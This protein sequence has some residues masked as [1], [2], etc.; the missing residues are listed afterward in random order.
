[1]IKDRKTAF[2]IYVV[3]FIV[4]WNI[5]EIL[6]DLFTGGAG[7]TFSAV[8][9]IMTPLGL[10]IVT[11]YLLF[12]INHA[13]INDELQTARSTEGSVIV[14]VRNPEEYLAGHIHGAINIPEDNINEIRSMIADRSTPLFTYCLR[15]SRST[16]AA[17]SLK[18]MGYT[19]VTNMGGINKYRGE[20]E[21]GQE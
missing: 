13:D 12:L 11:G 3:L 1:M 2:A 6:W 4:F 10:A 5:A 18:A 9:D 15:G 20:Q 21:T 14:D 19:N 17:R 16:R 8:T 7:H